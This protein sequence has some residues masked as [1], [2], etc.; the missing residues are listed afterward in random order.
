[1][2]PTTQRTAINIIKATRRAARRWIL[3]RLLTRTSSRYVHTTM[4]CTAPDG[5][6]GG[7]FVP[8][9]DCLSRERACAQ[10]ETSSS[11]STLL[12]TTPP[13]LR[14][15]LADA[16]LLAKRWSVFCT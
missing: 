7:A 5:S 3:T 13:C 9:A 15:S 2:T 4:R 1:M 6:A 12:S 8:F 11:S 16:R 14:M 10:S